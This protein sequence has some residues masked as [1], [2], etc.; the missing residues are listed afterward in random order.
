MT[1][2]LELVA[3]A[4]WGL[5]GNP[6]AMVG[7][8][9]FLLLHVMLLRRLGV[10][11]ADVERSV[12]GLRMRP[13]ELP[14]SYD[15]GLIRLLPASTRQQGT[16]RYPLSS[17]YPNRQP[18]SRCS[19][20]FTNMFHRRSPLR[21]SSE[22]AGPVRLFQY[23]ETLA[24]TT[25]SRSDGACRPQRNQVVVWRAKFRPEAVEVSGM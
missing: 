5:V 6:L 14:A 12:G 18:E 4:A 11:S 22:Y 1:L 10:A 24:S 19:E 23:S 25:R 3:E 9:D 21:F 15:C 16:P 17:F 20:C 2:G 13:G 8:R 7:G